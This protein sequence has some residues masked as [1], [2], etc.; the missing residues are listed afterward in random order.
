VR[1]AIL[2]AMANDPTPFQ[3]A[4]A[5]DGGKPY[6]TMTPAQKATF[7]A[8]VIICVCTFGFAFPNVQTD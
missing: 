1:R 4:M 3:K 8:K 5:H 7:I 2:I 6:A